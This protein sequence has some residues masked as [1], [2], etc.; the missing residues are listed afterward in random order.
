MPKVEQTVPKTLTKLGENLTVFTAPSTSR[1]GTH[2]YVFC[3]GDERGIQCTCEGWKY[4]ST[5][6]HVDAVPLCMAKAH[7]RPI[8]V[9]AKGSLTFN[10]TAISECY[11]VEGHQGGHSWET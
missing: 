8:G 1:P 4:N 9:T 6:W 11:F 3:Y 10:M 2:H 5:C 7:P